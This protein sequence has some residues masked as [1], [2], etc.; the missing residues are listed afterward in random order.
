MSEANLHGLIQEAKRL[1]HAGDD[2]EATA[3]A[4]SLA[5]KYPSTVEVWTLLAYLHARN[6]DYREAI[7]HVTRAIEIDSTEPSLLYD[8]GR[9]MLA[10]GQNSQAVS[11]FSKAIQLCDLH[12]SDYYREALHFLRAEAHLA[13]NAPDEALRDLAHVRD[14]F[15]AWTDRLRTKQQLVEACR[16]RREGN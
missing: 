7:S 3:L 10:I 1:A 13:R 8:R 4:H 9:Y 5:E 16:R 2:A 15:Q 12:R 14:G 6:R 11:D